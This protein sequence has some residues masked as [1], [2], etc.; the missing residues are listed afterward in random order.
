MVTGLIFLF[1][2][3]ISLLDR[4]VSTSPRV[5]G[6]TQTSNN[7]SYRHY[8]WSLTLDFLVNVAPRIF[9]NYFKIYIMVNTLLHLCCALIIFFILTEKNIDVN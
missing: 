4:G 9:I 1:G 8:C 2:Q 7:P 3:N 6:W 5:G